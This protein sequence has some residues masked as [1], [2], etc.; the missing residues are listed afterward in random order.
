MDALFQW[1]TKILW[2][3]ETKGTYLMA[4]Y[5]SSRTPTISPA[6]NVNSL[7]STASKSYSARTYSHSA[8]HHHLQYYAINSINSN[9]QKLCTE[10]KQLYENRVL[11]LAVYRNWYSK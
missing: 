1:M 11:R 7:S 9:S 4:E 5:L 2:R 8:M 10:L 6:V 3:R